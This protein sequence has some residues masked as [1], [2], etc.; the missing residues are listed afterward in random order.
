MVKVNILTH[1]LR[2]CFEALFSAT[3]PETRME[4]RSKGG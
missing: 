1:G 2:H 3:P 4:Q